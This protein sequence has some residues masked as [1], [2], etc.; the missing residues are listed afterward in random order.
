[1]TARPLPGFLVVLIIALPLLALGGCG[2]EPGPAEKAGKKI[3]RSMQKAADKV[4]E[5]TK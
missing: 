4:K 2:E 5:L 3:D 1:M